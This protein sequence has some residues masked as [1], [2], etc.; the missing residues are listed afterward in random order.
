[1]S[2]QT[3]HSARGPSFMAF[4]LGGVVVAVLA[5]GYLVFTGD[6]PSDDRPDIRIELPGG[7]AITGEV[8]TS[9]DN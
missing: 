8:D 2:D 1:M 4:V 6:M 3:Q 9:G 5:L 7:N